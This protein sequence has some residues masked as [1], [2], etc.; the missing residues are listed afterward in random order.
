MLLSK[1]FFFFYGNI[2]II[3]FLKEKILV[4][5]L[6]HYLHMLL[7]LSLNQ[8]SDSSGVIW[9]LE[10]GK[11]SIPNLNLNGGV[12][13][14]LQIPTAGTTLNNYCFIILVINR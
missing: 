12:V 8:Y 13:T 14:P 5:L 4:L 9:G 2:Y 1:L 3:I 6:L 10:K 11:A 7:S